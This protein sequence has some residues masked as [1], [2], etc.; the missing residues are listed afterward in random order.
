MEI[1][2]TELLKGE[3]M[4]ILIIAPFLIIGALIIAK[5]GIDNLKRE[6]KQERDYERLYNEIEGYLDNDIIFLRN[7]NY[8]WAQIMNLK[9]LPHKN[10]EKT[11][12]LWNKYRIKLMQV[13]KPE[14]INQI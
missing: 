5:Y 12:I 4:I 3:L 11:E 14:S 10:P 1:N 2:I 9:N 13:K 8:V 6:Q 7:R